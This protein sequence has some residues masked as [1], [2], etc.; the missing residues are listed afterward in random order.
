MITPTRLNPMRALHGLRMLALAALAAVAAIATSPTTLAGKGFNGLF[1]PIAGDG[2]FTNNGWKFENSPSD[3]GTTIPGNLTYSLSPDHST[4]TLVVTSP[5]GV[6]TDGRPLSSFQYYQDPPNL[7][8]GPVSFDYT[9]VFSEN[10]KDGQLGFLFSPYDSGARDQNFAGGFPYSGHVAY[11]NNSVLYTYSGWTPTTDNAVTC[12]ITLTNLVWGQNRVVYAKGDPVP[13]I[14]DAKFTGFGVPATN[15]YGQLAVLARWTSPTGSGKGIFVD[16]ELLVKAGDEIPVTSGVKIKAFKDP[17]IDDHGY[18]AVPVT[19]TGL[20]IT[21][22]NDAAVLSNAPGGTLAIVAQEG[23]Q[24][25]DAP[26][27]AL[28]RTFSSVALPGGGNGVVILGFM[29]QGTG[30]ITSANDNG[31]W[32]ADQTGAFRLRIQEGT[33]VV[34]GNTVKSFTALKSV[35]GT[36]GQTHAVN[37]SSDLVA[38][39]TYTTGAQALVKFT[40]PHSFRP[41]HITYSGAFYGNTAVADGVMTIDTGVLQNPGNGG[42]SLDIGSTITDVS[43]TISGASVGNGTFTKSDFVST[44]LLIHDALDL[45]TEWVGQAQPSQGTTWG[46]PGSTFTAGDLNFF[47]A[48]GNAPNGTFYFKLTTAGSTGD[49]MTLTSVTPLP[50]VPNSQDTFVLFTKGDAVPGIPDATFTSFGVPAIHTGG[51]AFLG[52]WK[53]PS[54][55]GAGIFTNGVLVAKLG[56][57]LSGGAGTQILKSL[58]DPVI[59]EY[60][61]V[62]FPAGLTGSGVTSANDRALVTNYESLFAEIGAPKVVAQ[63]G[64]VAVDTIDGLYKSFTSLAIAGSGLGP[65]WLATLAEG[66]SITKT[67]K[68][69]LWTSDYLGGHHLVLQSGTSEV[70]GKIVKSFKVLKAVSGSPGQTHSFSSVATVF[71]SVVFTDGSQAILQTLIPDG[72]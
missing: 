24:A 27:G 19:L 12:T 47:A 32:A 26:E 40:K 43:L 42:G 9:V 45:E 57:D 16:G 51:V 61:F 44:T 22:A 29:Q 8:P 62:A 11:S 37:S 36:P 7:P 28:W 67:N 21:S 63:E 46:E 56:D 48:D 30:G 50:F 41:F 64:T 34:Q 10:V 3:P 6:A 2:S 14:T 38:K 69:G 35:S 33:T 31:I 39:V 17:V 68:Q 70:D 20:G 60:G 15:I 49:S 23:T 13:G 59:D 53:G 1:N 4:L 71:S 18:V 55:S 66:G 54:G 25:P 65:I 52:K 72:F 5:T 58:K